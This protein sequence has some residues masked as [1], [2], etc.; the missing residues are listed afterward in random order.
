MAGGTN[1]VWE[2]NMRKLTGLLAVLVLTSASAFAQDVSYN[3]DQQAD[4]SKYKTYKWVEVKGGE[5]IDQLSKQQIAQAFDRQLA[6]KGLTKTD[7]D[8]ADLYIAFQVAVNLV[9]V[10][11]VG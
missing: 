3:Y 10:Y 5:E 1:V 4:F 7:A 6:T 9:V 11:L 8:T 2:R